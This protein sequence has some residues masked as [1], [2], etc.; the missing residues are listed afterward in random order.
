MGAKEIQQEE[1]AARGRTDATYTCTYTCAH[2]YTHIHTFHIHKHTHAHIYIYIY[3]IYIYIFF[4]IIFSETGEVR[5]AAGL[6]QRTACQRG[7]HSNWLGTAR[8]RQF[9]IRCLARA[10]ASSAPCRGRRQGRSPSFRAVAFQHSNW[11][12]ANLRR[13]PQS[14]NAALV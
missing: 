3:I 2:T 12:C 11:I 9:R 14:K 10:R 13:P 4:C 8:A 6:V 5:T 7:Q 1:E